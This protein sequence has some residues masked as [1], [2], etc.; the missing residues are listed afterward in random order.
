MDSGNVV[1][2]FMEF[3]G[4]FEN[5]A[6][7]ADGHIII[8]DFAVKSSVAGVGGVATEMGPFDV[9]EVPKEIGANALPEFYV[10]ETQLI[11]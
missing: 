7:V 1:A 4:G 8:G 5:V 10:V 6:S 11:W 3:F 2:V 9:T